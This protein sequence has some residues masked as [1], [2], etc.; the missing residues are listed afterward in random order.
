MIRF[1]SRFGT[2]FTFV[3]LVFAWMSRIS[4]AQN[5]MGW[6]TYRYVTQGGGTYFNLTATQ[7]Q[8]DHLDITMPTNGTDTNGNY[9]GGAYV[10]IPNLTFDPSAYEMAVTYRLNANHA[11]D[12]F[13]VVVRQ[14]DGVDDVGLS[15]GEDFQWFFTDVNN[16]F[17]NSPKD[18]DGFVTIRRDI[19]QLP[20]PQTGSTTESWDGRYGAYGYDLEGDALLDFNVVQNGSPNGMTEVQFQ[21]Q[22]DGDTTAPNGIGNYD[23]LDI[24]IK[25]VA[26]VPKSQTA[27][28]EFTNSGVTGLWGSFEAE[29]A[30]QRDNGTDFTN[31]VLDIPVTGEA[32]TVSG[33][34]WLSTVPSKTQFD[35]TKYNVEVTAKLLPGNFASEFSVILK[36]L[37]GYVADTDPMLTDAAGEEHG[38]N[39]SAFDLNAT[40]MTTLSMPAATPSWTNVRAY[41]F[42]AD[43]DGDLTDMNVFEIQIGTIFDSLDELNIEIESVR[44]V[45]AT[46]CDYNSDGSCTPDDLD[47]LYDNIGTAN[48]QF[49]ADLDGDVD[50]DDIGAWLTLASDTS[51]P[52]NTNAKT[53]VVGDVN[54]DGS[55]GSQDLGVLLNNF[56]DETGKKFR[57]G[58]L[59][60]D[61]AINSSDLGLMLN[62]FGVTSAS[63]AAV[64]EPAGLA[65]F[66]FGF[67]SLLGLARRRR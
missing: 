21:A 61:M 52:F 12:Q 63:A 24:S 56:N 9:G 31:V 6:D 29:G 37:D 58:N 3:L 47:L 62:N 48:T 10:G 8:W 32:G 15:M 44:L 50:A 54:F 46:S 2:G 65:L 60:G 30:F 5:V 35:A 27:P 64:P 14:N 20:N 33:G 51:N 43:G 36:D 34:A 19:T 4:F 41:N 53:F 17:A 26:L 39:F 59:N 16:H 25:S 18:A 57:D 38:Y 13:N 22:H 28:V 67:L 49:D 40:T 66:G 7:N 45:P 42:E 1:R 23:A 55:V 11:A